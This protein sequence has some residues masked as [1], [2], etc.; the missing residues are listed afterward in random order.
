MIA[1]LVGRFGAAAVLLSLTAAAQA[2]QQYSI[3]N[4]TNEQQYMLELTNRAR[5]DGGAEATRL[6]LAG[7]LQEGPPELCNETWVIQNSVQPLSWNP[8]LGT[9]AQ[10]H[11]K[12]LNDADQFFTGTSPHTFGGTTPDQ[13]I[14]AAGYGSAPYT[15]PTTQGGCFPGAENVATEVSF[16]SSGPQPYTGARLVQALLTAHNG[17]FVDNG[18]FG[19]NEVPGRGH[20][21]T[22]MLPWFREMGAGVTAGAD[23]YQGTTYDSVYIVHNF[24]SEDNNLPFI[25]GVVYSDTNANNFYDPGEGIGGVRVDVAGANFFAI[26][27]ASGGYSVPVPGNGTYNVTFSGGSVATTQRS[28]AV[29]NLQN[30]KVDYIV[31]LETEPTLLANISTR[32]R[33]ETGDNVLIGGFIITGNEPKQVILRALGPSL[34][35]RGIAGGLQDP[36]LELVQGDTS[37]RFND[38]WKDSQQAE[39]EAST[40]PPGNE[41]EAAIVATLDPGAYTAV[42]R[43]KNNSTGVG[44]VEIYDISRTSDSKLANIATRGLVQIDENVMIA[45]MIVTSGSASPQKVIVRAI[46]P[47]LTV[48]GKMTDPTLDLVDGNGTVLRSNDDWRTS[49]EAEIQASGVPPLD[50]AE[51]AIVETLAPGNYTAIVRGAGGST[52]VAVVEIYALDN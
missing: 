39:I 43:G 2:Q 30:A 24:G 26:S 40:I 14:A 31:P 11:S 47:S 33:V 20:R 12:T 19:G 29:A 21:N 41:A 18:M 50:N 15:G 49:Q 45:G 34:A 25:T 37:L 6:G 8:Q 44:L 32:L 46:G 9:A 1:P 27:S 13:R 17:L 4:P 48:S 3:G 38:D 52:G 36:T 28:A 10:N 23:Q 42:M 51:S 22:M 7:G 35:S 5:I 16:D